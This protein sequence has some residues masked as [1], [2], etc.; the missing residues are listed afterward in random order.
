MRWETD[1]AWRAKLPWY[2]LCD[3][4]DMGD[5]DD[6]VGM[7]VIQR[8][9]EEIRLIYEG[10]EPIDF[11]ICYSNEIEA[12]DCTNPEIDTIKGWFPFDGR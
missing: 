9:E 10:D 7:R 8:V 11:V 1:D 4:G 6:V 12:Q 2:S 3:D 5:D